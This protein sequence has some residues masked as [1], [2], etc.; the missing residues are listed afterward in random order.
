V[1]LVFFMYF[2]FA[3]TF[4]L[5]KAALQYVSPLLFIAIRMIAAGLLLLGYKYATADKEFTI[6]RND[7]ALVAR[8]I[9]FH[10][11]CA[12]YLEFWALQYVTSAKACLLYNL[13]PFITAVFSYLLFSE[14]LTQRQCL[15]LIVGFGGF[16]PILMT[17][18]IVENTECGIS[19]LSLYEAALI[20]SVTASAY[21]WMT[22]KQLMEKGYS[23]VVVNGIGMLGGGL[24]SLGMSFIKEGYPH[25]KSVPAVIPYVADVYSLSLE[26]ICMLGVYTFSLIIIANVIGYNM[27]AYLLTRYSATLL[28]FAG[29]VT[30]LFAAV[31][32]WLM[33]GEMVTWHFFATLVI[34]LYGLYLFHGKKEIEFHESGL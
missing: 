29:F 20:A 21:G 11:F 15:G 7:Y 14:R 16:I 33:L 9:F 28:S 26:N 3:C 2:L 24:L 27:Y 31:I 22:M 5:G 23:F 18:E 10:I 34:V 17:Q 4:T 12:Y 8:I 25:I 30:P 6:S 1:F 13:S 19:F 32:G